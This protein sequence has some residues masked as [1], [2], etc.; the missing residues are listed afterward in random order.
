MCEAREMSGTRYQF[1]D[2]LVE[3]DRNRLQ[4]GE[5]TRSLEPLAMSVLVFLLEKSGEVVTT[6]SLLDALWEGRSAEPGMVARCVAQIRQALEDDAKNPV[7]IETIR[8]RGYRT[9]APVTALSNVAKRSE[10]PMP[11]VTREPLVPAKS[12]D[13]RR[14]LL[15]LVAL[16]G[17]AVTIAIGIYWTLQIDEGGINEPN[18]VSHDNSIETEAQH[19]LTAISVMPFEDMSATGDNGW[20]ANGMAEAVAVY[21]ARVEE[22]HVVQHPSGGQPVTDLAELAEKR[23]TGSMVLGSIQRSEQKIR[24]TARLVNVGDGSQLWSGRFDRALDDIFDVQREVAANIVRAIEA[25]LGVERTPGSVRSHNEARYG[26][27]DV[28]AYELWRRALELKFSNDYSPNDEVLYK[29][30]EYNLEAV[31]ID[32]DFSMGYVGLGFTYGMV[33]RRSGNPQDREAQI[34]AFDRAVELGPENPIAIANRAMLAADDRDWLK[35]VT[36]IRQLDQWTDVIDV[37]GAATDYIIALTNLG[38]WAE[39][40]NALGV[41]VDKVERFPRRYEPVDRIHIDLAP[42]LIGLRRDY[43]RA[44]SHTEM[45]QNAKPAVF[46]LFAP[47]RGPMF[48]NAYRALG[49][50]AEALEMFLLSLPEPERKAARS[51]YAVD[52]WAGMLRN[53]VNLREQQRAPCVYSLISMYADLGEV[54][55]LNNCLQNPVRKNYLE[56]YWML[57]EFDSYRNTPP[58]QTMLQAGGIHRYKTCCPPHPDL[59]PTAE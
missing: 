16:L 21:L 11:G 25:K 7:Y 41:L 2:W 8:K 49:R 44:L 51:A 53:I 5:N 10:D 24:V 6:D 39:A 46:S 3:P 18:N 59:D 1:Q 12:K 28:R 31:A 55:Q 35:V 23:G 45:Y 33:F 34:E 50:D 13:N 22:L 56:R 17:T 42:L 9:I 54:E 20:L 37:G 29:A 40:D 19:P 27:S 36:L 57:P 32:P 30:L 4:N 38:R 47:L 43:A 14:S 58:F 26:A 48:A 15:T 52:D